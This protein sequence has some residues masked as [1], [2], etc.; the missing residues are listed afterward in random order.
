M[1]KLNAPSAT[2]EAAS[3]AAIASGEIFSIRKPMTF[4]SAFA[5]CSILF[6]VGPLIG[7]VEHP[8]SDIAARQK[9]ALDRREALRVRA[10]VEV[11]KSGYP[12]YA[13][14]S[15]GADE[16]GGIHCQR[17]TSRAT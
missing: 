6:A 14:P 17:L 4:V 5:K 9:A 2:G 13:S 8:E 12:S 16:T 15:C 11:I 3:K 7:R 10:E 1:R